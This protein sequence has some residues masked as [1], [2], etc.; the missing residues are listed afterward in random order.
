MNSVNEYF[1]KLNLTLAKDNC[2]TCLT[3]DDTMVGQETNVKMPTDELLKNVPPVS[4]SLTVNEDGQQ[5]FTQTQVGIHKK[6]PHVV[7]NSGHNE[8]YTQAYIIEAVKEVLG[9]IDVD[10]AS[11]DIANKTVGAKIYYTEEDNGLEQ[12]WSGKVFMNPPYSRR[13]ITKFCDLLVQKFNSNEVTE[14]IVLVNNATETRWF[15]KL[16]TCANAIC[17]P[18]GRI[19]FI[20]PKEPSKNAPLQGQAILYFGQ[21][22]L[23]FVKTFCSFGGTSAWN[24]QPREDFLIAQKMFAGIGSRII[25]EGQIFRNER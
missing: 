9:E 2:P 8:W 24:K 10:P 21:N 22:N 6:R 23:A 12:D 4:P 20:N 14:A 1:A 18:E 15:Q 5:I 17:L 19:D 11:S 3:T 13:L 25:N 7:Y 16:L